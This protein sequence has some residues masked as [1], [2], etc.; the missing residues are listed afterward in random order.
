MASSSG[1]PVVW[2]LM[3]SVLTE[4]TSENTA[5]PT[6]GLVGDLFGLTTGTAAPS[7]DTDTGGGSSVYE[8]N[9]RYEAFEAEHTEHVLAKTAALRAAGAGLRAADLFQ[10]PK[11]QKALGLV[12]VKSEAKAEI[13]R[14][15][16][17]LAAEGVG[18]H[19]MLV[20]DVF[21]TTKMRSS[22]GLND[23][24]KGFPAVQ[25]LQDMQAGS[26]QRMCEAV[27]TAINDVLDQPDA[28]PS[29]GSGGAAAVTITTAEALAKATTAIPSKSDDGATQE[30]VPPAMDG[31]S[32]GIDSYLC[33]LAGYD[34]AN[35]LAV[36][37]QAD[38]DTIKAAIEILGGTKRVST[39][40]FTHQPPPVQQVQ[41]RGGLPIRAPPIA[42]ISSGN[43]LQLTSVHYIGDDPDMWVLERNPGQPGWA[44]R[45]ADPV[46][47][48]TIS[49]V[50]LLYAR[51]VVASAGFHGAMDAVFAG[52][53]GCTVVHAPMKRYA[54]AQ[55][56]VRDETETGY[57]TRENPWSHLK[58]VLRVRPLAVLLRHY[59]LRPLLL[60]EV[61]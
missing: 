17:A 38:Q 57:A 3:R 7:I 45:L 46:Y 49:G 25:L 32:P 35:P 60:I 51:S 39:P 19:A 12:P 42:T 13:V 58:D 36:L 48:G 59:F 21:G 34:S 52:C 29:V 5:L 37:S 61:A 41:Q 4:T 18:F 50:N 28:T 2:A 47:Q 20:E 30:N 24:D 53:S 56:K 16:L 43:D 11:Y 26:A 9:C 10:L 33:N 44:T 54:R 6:T 55:A 27:E 15:A 8:P 1:K 31:K 22:G 23:Q 14:H 40:T